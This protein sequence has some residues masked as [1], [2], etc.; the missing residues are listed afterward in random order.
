M[1]FERQKRI[2]KDLFLYYATQFNSSVKEERRREIMKQIDATLDI[3]LYYK[4]QN[5]KKNH[6]K[7]RNRFIK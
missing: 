5:D 1:E 6:G 4:K 3:Y 2:A 7:R